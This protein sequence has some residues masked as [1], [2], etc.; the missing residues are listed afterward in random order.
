VE[1]DPARQNGIKQI[2]W[3][4]GGSWSTTGD[5]NG[6]VMRTGHMTFD[7]NYRGWP[8]ADVPFYVPD[9]GMFMFVVDEFVRYA[10]GSYSVITL[11]WSAWS[12][13]NPSAPEWVNSTGAPEGTLIAI[14]YS[15]NP[16]TDLLA[17]NSGALEWGSNKVEYKHWLPLLSPL[18]A[19]TLARMPTLPMPGLYNYGHGP[20]RGHGI[21]RFNMDLHAGNPGILF[22]DKPQTDFNDNIWNTTKTAFDYDALKAFGNGFHSVTTISQQDSGPLGTVTSEGFFGPNEQGVTLLGMRV[23]IDDSTETPPPPPPPP[24]TV[25]TCTGSVNGTSTDGTTITVTSGSI[26]CK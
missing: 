22:E 2:V 4:D 20:Q 10:N 5:P 24:P 11:Q 13:K 23:L 16:N 15:L 7:I 18:R 1:I 25:K 9:H 12:M 14:N 21:T 3:D 8:G 19:D 26:T 17:D 6:L